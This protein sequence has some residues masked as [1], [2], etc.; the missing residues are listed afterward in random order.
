MWNVLRDALLT[1]H[2]WASMT[3]P[4]PS[5]TA[6]PVNWRG[7]EPVP[8]SVIEKALAISPSRRGY[9]QRFFCSSVPAR[10]ISSELPES[11]AWL[12]NTCGPASQ[13][14]RISCIRPSF[15]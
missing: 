4:S 15:T 9:S 3:Q 7:S 13:A 14:P 6:W 8:G 10:A 11:G 2:L 12:P 5:R 1:N